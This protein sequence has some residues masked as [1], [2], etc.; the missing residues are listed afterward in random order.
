[1]DLNFFFE[2]PLFSKL[3]RLVLYNLDLTDF[4]F[5]SETQTDKLASS[6]AILFY[7]AQYAC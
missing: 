2:C 3:A 6:V 7:R 4:L 1:M 5:D